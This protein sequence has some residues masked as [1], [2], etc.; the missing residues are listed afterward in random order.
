MH[1]GEGWRPSDVEL[2]HVNDVVGFIVTFSS[3]GGLLW[4]AAAIEVAGEK[5]QLEF[6]IFPLHSLV[7]AVAALKTPAQ[8]KEY[9]NSRLDAMV[10]GVINFDEL[11]HLFAYV[12]GVNKLLCDVPASATVLP[13]QYELSDEGVFINPC[14]YRNSRNWKNRYLSELWEYSVPITPLV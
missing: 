4:N 14:K 7:L 10:R 9:L 6:S 1:W 2:D 12:S 3:Y 13:R 8:L 5:V 11:E